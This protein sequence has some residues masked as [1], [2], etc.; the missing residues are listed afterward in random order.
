[1]TV[2]SENLPSKVLH[3]PYERSGAFEFCTARAIRE[4]R[5]VV[6][7]VQKRHLRDSS[8]LSSETIQTTGISQSPASRFCVYILQSVDEDSHRD[9]L[10][11]ISLRCAI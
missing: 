7:C 9:L 6:A 4:L 5:D 1:M 3:K 8:P 10:R 11:N 2:V